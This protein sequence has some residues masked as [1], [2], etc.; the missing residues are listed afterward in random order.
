M[1]SVHSTAPS[2]K[3]IKASPPATVDASRA[4][5]YEKRESPIAHLVHA[6]CCARRIA[7]VRPLYRCRASE[8]LGGIQ[9]NEAKA[10]DA[11]LFFHHLRRVLFLIALYE[12]R[13]EEQRHF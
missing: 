13:Q 1:A 2:I 10:P 12:Q 6:L 11:Q 8:L 9:A 7:R 3:A 4:D 5:K